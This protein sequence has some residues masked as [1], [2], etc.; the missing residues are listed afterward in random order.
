MNIRLA[1]L[2][3]AICL[4]LPA[5]AEDAPDP[6]YP[7]AQCAAFVAG[8]DDY[9]ARSAYLARDPGDPALAA[10]LRAVAV[11][12]AGG[13]AGKVDAFI[14]SETPVMAFMFEAMIFGGDR[15]SR[16]MHD[17]LLVLCMEFALSQPET[18]SLR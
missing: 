15:A 16:D 8:R 12:Q 11:R 6:L 10:G 17:R 3:A 5:R 2:S 7:A 4:A 14:A 18:Q 9:A 1:A 13:D